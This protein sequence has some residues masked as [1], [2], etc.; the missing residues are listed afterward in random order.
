MLSFDEQVA[1]AQALEP[2]SSEHVAEFEWDSPLLKTLTA[3]LTPAG[4]TLHAWQFRFMAAA[5]ARDAEGRF[6]HR[7]VVLLV[8]RQQ[9]KTLLA[10]ARLAL[11]LVLGE[12][13]VMTAQGRGPAKRRWRD[14]NA[15]YLE[16]A[17]GEDLE[18][19]SSQG[20]EEVVHRVYGGSVGCGDAGPEG[21]EGA[22][23]GRVRDRRGVGARH[24]VPVRCEPDDDDPPERSGV[25]SVERGQ[26]GFDFAA[27][28]ARHGPRR[29]GGGCC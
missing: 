22:Y 28:C 19:R 9:G 8:A 20:D 5:L 25:V 13:A 15:D 29:R 4:V 18:V 24:R 1:R 26:A 21:A 3:I 2:A 17:F 27:P 6:L 12:K 14:N 10:A 11:A 16:P 23:F 7:H